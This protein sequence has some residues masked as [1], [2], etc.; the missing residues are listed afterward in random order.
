MTRALAID[1]GGSKTLVALVED[2]RVIDERRAQTEREGGPE[3][4]CDAIVE[5]AR[6][7]GG[8]AA[9]GAAV[10]GVVAD[11]HWKSM[12]RATL[13]IPAPF[14]LREA[15]MRRFGRPAVCFNDAQAA[16]WGEHRFGAG[17]GS[18]LVF[19]T[20]STGVG[21]GAVIG[22]AL[23]V[24]ARGLGAS[25][26]LIR[27]DVHLDAPPFEDLCA[28]RWMEAQAAAAGQ[29]GD[30]SAVFAAAGAGARWA[31]D[32][33]ALSA[34][35]IAALLLNIQLLFDPPVIVLGGGIGLAKG[36]VDALRERLG[37][38]PAIRRPDIRLAALGHC[39]GGVGVA[40]L[41]LRLA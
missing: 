38:R 29:S 5:L 41:S 2:G 7:L 16:A 13:A 18:D 34:D 20:V 40:D 31:L 39:A 19:V 21:G 30:A 12:N 11:G 35:R 15:L 3:G 1:L 17:L 22:G 4:W 8:F 37:L 28:G 36:Y 6:G 24:G 33:V 9:V 14:P 23:L 27:N 32:I 25:V 10:S 26:G